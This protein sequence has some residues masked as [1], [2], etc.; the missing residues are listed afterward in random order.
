MT[1]VTTN[2]G[3]QLDEFRQRVLAEVNKDFPTWKPYME[4]IAAVK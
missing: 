1:F 3:L 2:E 4:R